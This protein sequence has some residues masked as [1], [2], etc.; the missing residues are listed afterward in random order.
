MTD[1]T[2]IETEMP[3]DDITATGN[4]EANSGSVQIRLATTDDDILAALTLGHEA[5]EETPFHQ[6]FPYSFD[7]VKRAKVWRQRMKDRPGQYGIFIA[8]LGGETIGALF[9]QIGSHLHLDI[10]VAQVVS[11]FVRPA[12][13]NGLAAVKLV[14]GSE[15]WARDKGAVSIAINITSEVRMDTTDRF[16]RRLKYRQTGGN[17]EIILNADGI[18]AAVERSHEKH[19]ERR[20]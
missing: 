17:Y 5:L 3:I 10:P 13:R 15:A 8:D 1:K 20:K 9:A 19:Q 4:G 16:L 14:R 2:I 11:L 6:R 7:P 18:D 12:H